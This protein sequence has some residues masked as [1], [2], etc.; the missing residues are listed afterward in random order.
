V[1][2][3]RAYMISM[4]IIL[5]GTTMLLVAVTGRIEGY[6]KILSAQGVLLGLLVALGFPDFK[7]VNFVFL[8]AETFIIKAAVIP[9][10][11]TRIVRK[12][13]VLRDIEPNLPSI[14]S[15]VVSSVLFA[16]G[17]FISY[18]IMA[19][20]KAVNSLYFGISFSV[21]FIS[22]F[23]IIS[24][25]NIV[26]HVLGY[27]MLENGIFLLSLSIARDMPFIIDLGV[28]LDIFTGVYLLGL[29]VNKIQDQFDRQDIDTLTK[30][31][32]R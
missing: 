21:I 13:G 30:L 3:R 11:L 32:D 8:I 9:V 15:L 7:P 12:N 23:V 27:M 5:F 22:L 28:L 20:S 10:F 29:F 2:A 6:I 16:A 25:K 31:R 18:W 17:F 26:T 24:K 19:Y 4:I 14:Y 1:A